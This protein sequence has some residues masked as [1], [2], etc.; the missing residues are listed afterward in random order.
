M[1]ERSHTLSAERLQLFAELTGKLSFGLIGACYVAGLI[2][3]SMYLNRYGI[4]SISIF[5]VSYVTAGFWVILP[6]LISLIIIY[7]ALGL[8][9]V[10]DSKG[11]TVVSNL[12]QLTEFRKEIKT[13]DSISWTML[14]NFLLLIAL[15]PVISWSLGI[16]LDWKWL[17][18]LLTG[19]LV[20]LFLIPIYFNLAFSVVPGTLKKIFHLGFIIVIE[21]LLLV[22]HIL[23]FANRVYD[24]IPSHIGGGRPKTVQFIIESEPKIRNSLVDAGISFDGETNRTREVR[25]LFVTEEEYIILVVDS[26]TNHEAPV[27]IRRDTVKATLYRGD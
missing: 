14:G 8:I 20:A 13:K 17:L 16:R 10:F 7:G 27:S 9:L 18:A 15:F 2:V 3:V 11:S 22:V 19:G 4:Y 24:T 25:L 1:S 12:L 5:R 6:I 26:N 21:L 23:V